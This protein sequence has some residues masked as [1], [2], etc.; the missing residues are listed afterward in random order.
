M[1]KE[2][3]TR[4]KWT[5]QRPEDAILMEDRPLIIMGEIVRQQADNSIKVMTIGCE[6]PHYNPKARLVKL[7]LIATWDD[8]NE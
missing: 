5:A 3:T 1:S 7:E 8:P 4:S 2:Y 6:T